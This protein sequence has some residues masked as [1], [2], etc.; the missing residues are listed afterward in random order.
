MIGIVNFCHHCWYCGGEGD[1]RGYSGLRGVVFLMA[2]TRRSIGVDRLVF[3]AW[4]GWDLVAPEL[5]KQD[6]GVSQN[7]VYAPND[8]FQWE[9][10]DNQLISLVFFWESC[11]QTNPIGR[12]CIPARVRRTE[13]GCK[14]D[15]GPGTWRSFHAVQAAEASALFWSKCHGGAGRENKSS[16]SEHFFLCHFCLWTHFLIVCR[17]GKGSPEKGGKGRVFGASIL[18]QI[19]SADAQ[20]HSCTIARRCPHTRSLSCARPSPTNTITRCYLEILAKNACWN[21]MLIGIAG[22][23]E[24]TPIDGRTVNFVHFFSLSINLDKLHGTLIL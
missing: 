16:S 18:L 6:L 14:T 3:R 4:L 11:F 21:P 15:L 5:P 8:Q 24:F 12:D 1:D 7:G 10:N 23:H 20:L 2:A 13:I 22:F 9:N 17:A 19:F